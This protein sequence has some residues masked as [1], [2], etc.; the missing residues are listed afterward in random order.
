MDYEKLNFII[1]NFFVETEILSI[2]LIN[3]GNVNT[4]YIFE[5]LYRG[6]K[7]KCILQRLSN[8]FES[9]EIVNLNH[10]ILTDHI[11]KKKKLKNNDFD[12]HRKR[13]EVPSLIKC[14]SNNLFIYPFESN[15]WRVMNYID[16]TFNLCCLNDKSL[17]YEV[18]I[19]L[20]KFHWLCS[21]IDSSKIVNSIN[22]FHNT[23]F[24]LDKYILN[25]RHFGFTNLD[26][27]I[28]KRLK[29]LI[30]DLS[31]HLDFIEP[32]LETIMIESIDYNIIH[33]DPKLSNFLFDA[34][35]EF[36]VSL[37]DLDT[38]SSGSLMTDLA[39]CIR[40]ICNLQGE[41]PLNKDDV[42]F[43]INSFKYFINGYFLKMDQ[44]NYDSYRL[45]LEYIYVIIFE[46]TIRFL[47]DFLESNK[48][49]KIEYKT[50]NLFRAEVQF[51]LLSSFLNQISILSNHLKEIGFS[52]SSTFVA[53]V[54]TII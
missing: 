37:I 40:S 1:Q 53:D 10:Q 46:L 25:L 14:K 41:D 45:L 32:I 54:Q 27:E 52:T 47:T 48:Y 44:R 8:V 24:Y 6:E 30:I 18:G 42:F 23:K 31:K 9:H 19:G 2:D 33:G 50:H 29:N 4:T 16:D 43:D 34:Q 26:D 38:I 22:Y 35:H 5:H 21:D 7:S 39:D 13:W 15:S 11:N 20:A 12:F 17:A 49:F 51:R 36:V 28:N 3:R